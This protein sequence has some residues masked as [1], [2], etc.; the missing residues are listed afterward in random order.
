[1][2]STRA[3]TVRPAVGSSARADAGVVQRRA[4]VAGPSFAAQEA[5]LAPPGDAPQRDRRAPPA[6]RLDAIQRS[7]AEGQTP[8]QRKER[9]HVKTDFESLELG[10]EWFKDIGNWPFVA[11]PWFKGS[12]G[13]KVGVKPGAKVAFGEGDA[14]GC[15]IS[16]G[17]SLA[18]SL[19]AEL[20]LVGVITAG[21]TGGVQTSLT[22][23]YERKGTDTFIGLE[24]TPE[25][26]TDLFVQLGPGGLV[27]FS[28][29][30]VKFPILKAKL[31]WKNGEFKMEVEASD[32][33]KALW[34]L[35]QDI[36]RDGPIDALRARI[37]AA[38]A[39]ITRFADDMGAIAAELGPVVGCIAK[40]PL[41]I[42]GGMIGSTIDPAK[43]LV[44]PNYA[45]LWHQQGGSEGPPPAKVQGAIQD[46]VRLAGVRIRK[47]SQEPH[48]GGA[49]A[50]L[51]YYL[52]TPIGELTGGGAAGPA[53]VLA[54]AVQFMGKHDPNSRG[55]LLFFPDG[56]AV[57]AYQ[58]GDLSDALG[59][60]VLAFDSTI[61]LSCAPE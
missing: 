56:Q 18:G 23:Q 11:T 6:A 35:L 48:K 22:A 58:I 49:N 42:I 32:E 50:L 60:S 61:T 37:E 13:G 20:G 39:Q 40:M 45:S 9:T 59:D 26:T 55:L 53:R 1:M 33:V 2:V 10:H 25:V 28:Y 43:Y 17:G 30:L 19:T 27:R 34:E 21:A 47:K 8:V 16:C 3:S 12:L 57:A 24:L 7:F 14:S 31:G 44:N 52:T 5:A 51:T 36:V 54:E 15:K 46:I 29:P 41:D 4:A 38:G